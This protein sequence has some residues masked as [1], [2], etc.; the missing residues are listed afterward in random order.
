MI[1]KYKSIKLTEQQTKIFKQIEECDCVIDTGRRWGKTFLSSAI[2]MHCVYNNKDVLI[3]VSN[4][5]MMH[6]FI[7]NIKDLI[8]TTVKGINYETNTISFKNGSCIHFM[9]A[10]YPWDMEH[11][12][13]LRLYDNIIF[14]EYAFYNYKTL[15]R[16]LDV[17]QPS[18]RKCFITTP[19]T[20]PNTYLVR[21]WIFTQDD[22]RFF[23]FKTPGDVIELNSG[24]S[25]TFFNKELLAKVDPD[26]TRADLE[27]AL[28][29]TKK[30]KLDYLLTTGEDNPSLVELETLLTNISKYSLGAD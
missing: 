27:L 17:L 10:D 5:R 9:H 24:I 4:A 22:F 29:L 19:D 7:D 3:I 25:G 23:R 15:Q 12:Y 26:P 2:A 20:T 30:L 13:K 14:E 8:L 21:K 18:I 28:S 1:T 16:I 11:L 6:V